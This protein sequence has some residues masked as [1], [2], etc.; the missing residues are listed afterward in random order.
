[1]WIKN[2]QQ[3]GEALVFAGVLL[4]GLFPVVTKLSFNALPPMMSLAIGTLISALMFG[5]IVWYQGH[6]RSLLVVKAL[7]PILLATLI[8]GIIYYSFVFAGIA[9]TTAGNSGIMLLTEVF[10]TFL[11]LTI[12]GK[13]RFDLTHFLGAVCVVAGAVLALFPGK[14]LVNSGDLLIIAGCIFP[15][16]GNS[17]SREAR[18]LVSSTV[19]LFWRNLI[20]GVLLCI[21]AFAIYGVPDEAALKSSSLLLLLNGLVILGI[22]KLFWIEAIHR[23][24]ISK[25]ISLSSMSP[26]FTLLFAYMLLGEIPAWYQL[27]ALLPMGAGIYLLTRPR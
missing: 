1:M 15:P 2:S 23:I 21:A 19:I 25:A 7:R 20:G 8:N 11:I 5:V 10:F 3:Q 12:L 14:L 22:S 18:T 27:G 9:R 16:L 24:S 26:L 4:W 13:E 6:G 17:Y